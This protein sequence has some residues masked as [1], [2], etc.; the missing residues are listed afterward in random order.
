MTRPS[1]IAFPKKREVQLCRSPLTPRAR[2]GKLE[3]PFFKGD[4]R[5]IV[6]VPHA[7]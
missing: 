1:Y 4:A 2:W 6:D 7:N 5:G 3:V